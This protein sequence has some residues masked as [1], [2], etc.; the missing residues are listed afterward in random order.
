M[1]NEMFRHRITGEKRW[2]IAEATG[3][4]AL[5]RHRYVVAC[6]EAGDL[7]V[8]SRDEFYRTHEAEVAHG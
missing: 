6:N 4:G 2:F 5:M 8:S 3:A 7:L 1:A